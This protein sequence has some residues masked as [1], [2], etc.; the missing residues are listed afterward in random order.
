MHKLAFNNTTQLTTGLRKSH[1]KAVLEIMKIVC[2]LL[3]A[4]FSATTL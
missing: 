1:L 2:N 3:G 4:L